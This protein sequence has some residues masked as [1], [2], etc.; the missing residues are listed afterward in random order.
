MPKVLTAEKVLENLRLGSLPRLS[1]LAGPAGIGK[2]HFLL[3]HFSRLI[4]TAPDPF[5]RDLLYLL[6]SAE[7]RERI[8]DLMLRKEMKGFLGERVLTFNR[9]MQEFLRAGDWAL[10]TDAERKFLLEEIAADKAG[11]YFAAV[12]DLPGFW[13]KTAEFIGELKDSLVGLEAFRKRV[14]VLEKAK[15]EIRAKY[16]AL[17]KIYEAYETRLEALGAKDHRDGPFLLRERER[18]EKPRRIFRH[19]FVDGFFDF[20]RAQ[21]EFLAWLAQSS[22]RI[23]LALTLDLSEGREALFEIPRG[24]LK[25]LKRMGFEA[26]DLGMSVNHRVSSEA[27]RYVERNLFAPRALRPPPDEGLL[28]SINDSLLILEA[29]GTRGEM[30]MI[31]RRIRRIVRTEHLNYS[32]IAVIFRRVGSYEGI[33]RTVFREFQIPVEVHERE[34]LRDSALA[35]TLVSFFKVLLED[36][37]RE[38]LFNFL[39]SSYVKGRPSACLPPPALA[40]RAG[41]GTGSP[42]P[43]EAE[44]RDPVEKD[45]DEVCSLEVRGFIL[46]ILSGRENWLRGFSHPLFDKLQ[47]FQE[48]SSEEQ[49]V[50]EWIQWTREVIQAFGLGRIPFVYQEGSRRDFAVLKRFESLLEEIRFSS[51]SRPNPL[52]TLQA[53][54]REFLGL[55][56]V[57]LFSLHDRDKNRVQ[58]YDIS[59]ARQKEYKV[60]FLAGLLEKQFPTEIREDP[61]LSDE[62]RKIAGLPERLPRQA[63]ERYFFYLGASRARSKLIL[64]YPR[65]DLEGCEALPS[66]Y[67]DEVKGLFPKDTLPERRYAA[68]QVLPRIEDAVSE[69]EVSAFILY[70]LYNKAGGRNRQRRCFVLTLYNRFLER[71]SFRTLLPRMLFEPSAQILDEKVRKAFLPR[72]GIF[73]PTGLETYGHC[74]YRYFAGQV[75]KLEEREEGIDARKVGILLHEVLEDYWTERVKKGNESLKDLE[76]A[77]E[78]MTHDLR[79]HLKKKPLIGEKA[80]RTELKIREMEDWLSAVVEKEILEGGT[81]PGFEPAHFEL[82]F[83]F[84]PKNDF[85]KLYDPFREEIK[86]RGKMDRVEV[87]SSDQYALVLDYKTGSS[88]DSKAILSGKALQLPLYL[89]ALQKLYKLKPL[90][91]EIFQINKAERKGFYS[92]EALRALQL[93]PPKRNVLERKDF[94]RLLERTVQF[95]HQFAEGI[96]KAEIPVRPRDCD[97]HCPFPSVCRIEKWRLKFI[98]QEI[99]E[100]DKK[101][102]LV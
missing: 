77:K 75:L 7:H 34:R 80:Y 57:D 42:P 89:L 24:T 6:P 97:P 63:V 83:G 86:L 38:D 93:E 46:G 13:E 41:T 16:E 3:N 20:S 84:P 65:F 96:L 88:F 98:E 78:F 39:K 40:L 92:A 33:L 1:I 43:A 50:E 91:G 71:P 37:K 69:R 52:R 68:N 17:F 26:V 36:W 4:Q 19:L 55:I 49:T 35:Q 5:R 76:K 70:E 27:L 32:D 100:E 18:A 47:S 51:A 73:K 10:V 22:E 45:Y 15:P 25:E 48:R 21:L 66:F 64:S 59:L 87:D 31:A 94:D 99:R 54:A 12:R 95:S 8:I 28:S 30:E 82:E 29:T 72:E 85:L 62:E 23:T 44:A 9:L 56:E 79:E 81:F 60:V 90:G 53:F 74:P 2:T 61:I 11:D 101:N 102:G 58:V 67:V 14:R